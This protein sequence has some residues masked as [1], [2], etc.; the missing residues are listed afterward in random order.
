MV[1]AGGVIVVPSR[2]TRAESPRRAS[3]SRISATRRYS[4]GL[5]S[6]SVRVST[7]V[8]SATGSAAITG[9]A[10]PAALVERF[11]SLQE[12]W[13]DVVGCLDR[14]WADLAGGRV[15][16]KLYR[17]VKVYRDAASGRLRS[18]LE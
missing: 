6:N 14:L 13:D 5:F 1:F 17:Q 9:A 18:G 3:V 15:R 4:I 7:G 11:H 8:A 2:K 16:V 10:P 12:Q